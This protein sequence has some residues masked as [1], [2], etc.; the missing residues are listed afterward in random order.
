M[1]VCVFP[2][3]IMK[4]IL[5]MFAEESPFNTWTAWRVCPAVRTDARIK[6]L[7]LN[8][9]GWA[10]TNVLMTLV[11]HTKARSCLIHSATVVILYDGF[12]VEEITRINKWCVEITCIEKVS[13][14]AC[15][16]N[17]LRRCTLSKRGYND[18]LDMVNSCH[19]FNIL[20]GDRGHDGPD[21]YMWKQINEIK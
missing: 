7:Y 21:G 13:P 6:E 8:L 2:K 19:T 9:A 5:Y 11:P 4:M 12:M 20:Q 18:H 17:M 15:D 1:S 10:W 14:I 16:M 3:D